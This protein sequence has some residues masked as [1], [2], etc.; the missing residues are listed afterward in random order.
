[1]AWQVDLAHTQV[2]F[3]V[4]H[5]GISLIRGNMQVADATL[6]LNE[7]QPESSR[8]SVR[9]DVGSLDTRDASRDGHLKSADFFDTGNHPYINFAT[10]DV[11]DLGNGKCEIAGNLT[12]RGVTRPLTLMGDYS[13]PVLDPISGKRKV[14]FLLNGEV[15]KNDF[16]IT[17]NVPM[18]LNAFMLADRVALTIDAQAIEADA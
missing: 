5:L 2:A 12:I 11:R 17:W 1:M 8:I 9:V 7:S 18:E 10:T 6:D 16:G 13:G 4:R 3:A 15:T 14:G